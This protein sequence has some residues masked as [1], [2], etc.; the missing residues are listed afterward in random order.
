VTG[1]GTG[2]GKTFVCCRLL[3]ALAVSRTVRCLKPVITGFDPGRP[4][5][6]DTALLLTAQ[7]KTVNAAN[8]D[9]TSPWRYQDAMSADM[10]ARRDQRPLPF[11]DLIEYSR[12]PAGPG[13]NLI[14][15]VG[16]VMA[17]LNDRH[18]VLDWIAAIETAVL[19]VT[20]SYLGSLSHTLTALAALANR[21][22][23]PI[24]IVISQSEDEPVPTA[25]SAATLRN[26]VSDTPV[27]VMPRRE[28][29]NAAEL[30]ALLQAWMRVN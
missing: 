11:P 4:E 30:A 22:R 19:L 6:S 3:E 7:G 26:F 5:R 9:S 16:G 27:L 18:T 24:A 2:I 17:P 20:G 13:L 25:E 15:G 28:R 21:S 12:A 23:P 14:E 29:A 8:I 10:A 1:T